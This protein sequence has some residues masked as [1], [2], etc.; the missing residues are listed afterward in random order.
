M[1]EVKVMASRPHMYLSE[2]ANI[3][4]GGDRKPLSESL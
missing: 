3:L 4:C 2:Q 1:S